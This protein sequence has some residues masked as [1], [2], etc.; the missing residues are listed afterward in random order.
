MNQLLL[1]SGLCAPLPCL[2]TASNL[3]QLAYTDNDACS[4]CKFAVRM[5]GDMLCDPAVDDQLVSSKQPGG[6]PTA[7]ANTRPFYC[8]S[9]MVGHQQQLLRMR[10]TSHTGL[11]ACAVWSTGAVARSDG[12][13]ADV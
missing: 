13:L 11:S 1:L 9:C 8:V 2:P 6:S 3:F 4:T 10:L 7:A 5:L 12:V